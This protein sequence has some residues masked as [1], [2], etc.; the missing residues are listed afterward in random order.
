MKTNLIKIF[1][2]VVIVIAMNACQDNAEVSNPPQSSL[3]TE[4]ISSL[5][6]R[7][8][9][10]S[11]TTEEM[12]ATANEF[13]SLNSEELDY[14]DEVRE[15]LDIARLEAMF[16]NSNSEFG[17]INKQQLD[18]LQGEVKEIAKV[19]KELNARSLKNHGRPYNKLNGGEIDNLFST[20]N[21]SISFTEPSLN[22]EAR[23]QGCPRISFPK[24]IKNGGAFVGKTKSTYYQNQ[25]IQDN[26]NDC[27]Y[28]LAYYGTYT[29]LS[30]WTPVDRIL[31]GLLGGQT[32]MRH[33]GYTD[34]QIGSKIW[35]Y[36]HPVFATMRVY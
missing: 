12:D 35:I 36:G 25:V 30:T 2:L 5:A 32:R 18:V 15:Q 7:M 22:N 11:L 34:V 6:E 13:R 33:T 8:I 17:R 23:I 16:K 4:R 9:S 10:T 28:I 26:D 14:F 19:R 20:F 29:K 27:D 3:D 24:T 31:V 21:P 1:Q